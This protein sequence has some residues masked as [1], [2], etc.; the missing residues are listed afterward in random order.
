M[1]LY[2]YILGLISLAI[3]STEV[4][5][6][7]EG[8]TEGSTG[9]GQ[10]ATSLSKLIS[11]LLTI[12]TDIPPHPPTTPAVNQT[13]TV[14]QSSFLVDALDQGVKEG[15]LTYEYE[16]QK[17]GIYITTMEGVIAHGSL[18]QYWALLNATWNP[19][20]VGASCYQLTKDMEQILFRIE[21]W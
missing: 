4:T 15:I 10:T 12:Y 13:V 5:E 6:Q 17:Y 8:G 18:K 14:N 3:C 16:L 19:L 2:L 7:C 20:P 9:C 21:T 1:Q 11:V